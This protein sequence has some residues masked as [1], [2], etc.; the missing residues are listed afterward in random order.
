M[1]VTQLSLQALLQ[2]SNYTG[3]ITKW[4]TI[5]G[6]FDNKYMPRISI[7]GKV[8]ADLVAEI[9]E[10]AE[11]DEILGMSVLTV[12]TSSH[13]AW[14]VYTDEAANQKGSGVGIVLVSP[15]KIVVENSL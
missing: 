12:S 9:T 11:G 13:V 7:K 4:G 10:G 5:L 3:R 6:A 14:E 15:K 1:V 8:L 2:K